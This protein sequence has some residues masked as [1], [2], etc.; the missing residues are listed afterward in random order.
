[1]RLPRILASW[2]LAVSPVLAAEA[3]Q[4][5]AG[6]ARIDITPAAGAALPM[7]GYAGRTQG[8]TKIHDPLHVRAIVVDDGASQAAMI[9]V[10]VVGIAT[11]LAEKIIARLAS[12]THIAADHVLLAAV[13]THAAPAI[14]TYS[15]PATPDIL[16]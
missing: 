9:G 4:L 16:E 1:M 3:G 12:E 14:G 5:R 7:S 8:F 6:A 13:H 15:E 10:E 2:C 11:P